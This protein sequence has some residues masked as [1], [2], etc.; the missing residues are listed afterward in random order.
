MIGP[1]SRAVLRYSTGIFEPRHRRT[2]GAGSRPVFVAVSRET[3]EIAGYYTLSA[4]R[5]ALS[6]LSPQLSKKLPRYPVVPAA[7]LGRLAVA[8]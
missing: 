6:P 4:T 7:S 3:E 2:F 1:D 5:V 8:R